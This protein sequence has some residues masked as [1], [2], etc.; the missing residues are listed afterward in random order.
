[1]WIRGANG[2]SVHTAVKVVMCTTFWRFAYYLFGIP[3]HYASLFIPSIALAAIRYRSLC[4][5]HLNFEFSFIYFSHFTLSIMDPN[6]SIIMRVQM[7]R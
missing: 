1:L 6:I 4:S 2:T 3:N 7:E 5:R